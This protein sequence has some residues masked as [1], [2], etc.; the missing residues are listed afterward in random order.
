M[1][2]IGKVIDSRSL[3][4]GDIIAIPLGKLGFGYARSY[5]D[6]TLGIYDYVTPQIESLE[7]IVD[8]KIAFFVSYCDPNPHDMD[9]IFLGKQRFSHPEETWGPPTYIQDVLNPNEFR[10]YHKGIMRNASK[11]EVMELEKQQLFFPEHIRERIIREIVKKCNS[12][13]NL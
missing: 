11:S 10:I 4:L 6:V 8:N 2:K 3:R 12:R 5:R 9:W 13:D 7:N 1:K